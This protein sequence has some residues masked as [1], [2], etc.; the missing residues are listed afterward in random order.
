MK[1]AV[2]F[3]VYNEAS[4]K[5][6][7]YF[8]PSLEA[9]LSFLAP[10]DY[11]V[12]VFDNSSPDNKV[13]RLALKAYDSGFDQPVRP[14][15]SAEYLTV[16]RN[17]GFGAA[18]NILIDSALAAGA[19]YFLVI[20][21][22][23]ILEPTAI[24]ELITALDQEGNL[25]SVAPKIRRWDFVGRAKTK[26]IDS[27]GL[28]LRPGL[29]FLDWG[30]GL[31][32]SGQYDQTAILGPSGAAGLFRLSALAKIAERRGPAENKKLQYFDER[33]FMYKEDC[34]LAYRLFLAGYE[35]RLV[36]AAVIYH[37]RTAASSGKGIWNALS[38]R[39]QKS[40]LVRS[41]SFLGQHLIFVKHWKKQN[42]TGRL[43]IMVN[44]VLMFIFSLI[45]ERFLLKQYFRLWRLS[46]LD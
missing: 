19:E 1:L 25:A 26:V 40:R 34:D 32:D 37:D 2:G 33:F 30:Q 36:P 39:R 38:D 44:L 22:D 7:A 8:L 46:G 12:Y 4:A 6:L 41:W 13:N 14:R 21:P 20:N 16:G 5:Y 27:C 18:Y 42:I 31:A 45:L 10:D 35:S 9:A 3:V 43:K 29:K 28:V 11:R 23:T 17:L 15:Q 24:K